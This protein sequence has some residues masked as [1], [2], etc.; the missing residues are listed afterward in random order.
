[1]NREVSF[2]VEHP[3]TATP[4]PHYSSFVKCDHCDND[5]TVHEVTVRNGV[6]IEKHLCETCAQ[7]H[8]LNVQPHIP[9]NELMTKFLVA[10][11]AIPQ[12]TAAAP[13]VATCPGCKMTFAEFRQGGV[14][15]CPDCY[16]TFEAQLTPLIERAHEGGT[17]HAGK[18]PRRLSGQG[19]VEG[20]DLSAL[21]ALRQRAERLKELKTALDE[22]I[23]TEQ[24][25]R[26][27]RLRDELRKLGEPG[28]K[29][30]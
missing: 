23:C 26:A 16:K 30:A 29:H 22:A 8:G 11:G 19:P 13:K 1:M 21:A 7:Q 9:I 25:E 24:Y 27:A 28:E 12:G 5:A 6:K 10:H 4:F 3:P 20:V 15:G 14:L 2:R 17:K 18:T